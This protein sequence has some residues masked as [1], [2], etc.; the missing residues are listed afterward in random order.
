MT[1][2]N[3][4]ITFLVSGLWHGAS[5]NYVLWGG[6]HGMLLVIARLWPYD[7]PAAG[8]PRAVVTAAQ[9][10]AMFVLVTIGWLMFR[11][12]E[13]SY[14]FRDL[15]QSPIGAP[16]FDRQAGLYLFLLAFLYSVPLWVHGIWAL[17]GRP[18]LDRSRA[19]PV[20]RT[21]SVGDRRSRTGRPGVRSH[22]GVSQPAVARFHL[23]SVLDGGTGTSDAFSDCFRSRRHAR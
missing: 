14:L 1:A 7:R 6:Y 4:M 10:I 8:V 23:F 17:Y 16:L 12:T 5:W 11:E 15:T 22:P 19:A 21:E 3:L 2:R 9:T 20:T 13:T 18:W